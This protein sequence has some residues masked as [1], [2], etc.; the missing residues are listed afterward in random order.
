M[1]NNWLYNVLFAQR[2]INNWITSENNKKGIFPYT[3]IYAHICM[4]LHIQLR[5]RYSCCI[6][7]TKWTDGTPFHCKG[8]KFY[9][10]Y[11]IGEATTI[12]KWKEIW[13]CVVLAMFRH[14]LCSTNKF[15]CIQSCNTLHLQNSTCLCND[16]RL[17]VDISNNVFW[18]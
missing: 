12:H 3:W 10:L 16:I 11:C 9:W 2:K 14:L 7:D 15:R 13:E 5:I 8:R 1:Q 17:I 4:L 6:C 18:F